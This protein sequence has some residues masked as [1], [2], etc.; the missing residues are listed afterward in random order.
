M[1][2]AIKPDRPAHAE[3]GPSSLK[4]VASCPGWQNH[5]KGGSAAD[6]GTRVHEALETGDRNLLQSEE[7]HEMFEAIRSMEDTIVEPL[8]ELT[9]VD[10]PFFTVLQ[11]ETLDL[12][13]P[14]HVP[15]TYGT[16]DKI[17]IH[18]KDAR[19]ATVIDYKTGYGTIDPPEQNYQAKAYA[20]G[21]FKRF[22]F[23]QIVDFHFIVPRNGGVLSGTF[24]RAQADEIATEI[25]RI[26][27]AGNK[28]RS[29]W[30]AGEVPSVSELTPND[31]CAWCAHQHRCP[32]QGH[33]A[34]SIV[35]TLDPSFKVPE[36]LDASTTSPE[37][38]ASLLDMAKIIEGWVERVQ[39]M[40]WE[41]A[42]AGE[43]IPGYGLKPNGATTTVLDD[44]KAVQLAIESGVGYKEADACRKLNF[45]AL[46][47][48][49]AK[50]KAVDVFVETA[51]TSG[52]LT[53]KPKKTSLSKVVG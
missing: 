23:V 46:R 42:D 47:K 50:V 39:G 25:T 2:T 24:I 53:V 5:G 41:R 10:D 1:T 44:E 7:E 45:P 32:A 27:D 15:E 6:F 29:V 51:T 17:I 3:F 18:G 16:A 4:H 49:L 38:L 11:E 14:S 43:E 34:A 33:L 22:R 8:K 9:G 48:E 19:R 13:L 31:G 28:V 52:F 35:K 12:H 37:E 20:L 40:A 21:V 30:K 36:N 26:I